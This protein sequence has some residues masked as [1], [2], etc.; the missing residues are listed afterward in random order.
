MI[1]PRRGF[2]LI[3]LLV[4]IA[5]VGVLCALVL[6]AI[7]A[8]RE[9]ARRVQCLNNLK[10]M[11]LALHAYHETLGSLP[12]GYVSLPSPDPLATSPG[13]SWAAMILPR[14]E[15]TPLYDSANFDLAV[16]DPANHTT[17]SAAVNTYIC[18]ADRDSGVYTV[19]GEADQ[20]IGRFHTNS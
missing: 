8:A 3:E 17:R 7:Q 4:V 2:T 18:P 13:W 20:P 6:P 14:L 11:G 10:Q 5:I 16:E 9:A 1:S 19:M 12:M 15:Q